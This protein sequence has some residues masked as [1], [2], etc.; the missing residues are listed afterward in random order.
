LG[1]AALALA[2]VFHPDVALLDIGMPDVSGYEVARTLRGRPWAARIRLVALTGWGQDGDR[3]QALD[4]GFDHHL[5]KPVDPDRLLAL[6]AD[7]VSTPP[8]GRSRLSETVAGVVMQF[9]TGQPRPGQ[10][11][12]RFET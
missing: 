9:D 10:P 5:I 8:L 3:R 11:S 1:G 6:L 12:V 2:D 7:T 4:A